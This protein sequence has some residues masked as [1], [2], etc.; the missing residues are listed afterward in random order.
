M[1]L[2]GLKLKDKSKTG[3][4]PVYDMIDHGTLDVL[5]YESLKGFLF[6]L[7]VEQDVSE[8]LN[9]RG[10][11]FVEP[12]TNYILKF[13]V[14]T[15]TND[16]PLNSC[17]GVEK[18]TES[19]ES[20]LEEAKLQQNCWLRSISGGHP[21]ICPSVANFSLFDNSESKKL[22]TFLQTKP[23]STKL[24]IVLPYLIDCCR[25]PSNRLGVIVMPRV[26]NCKP[27]FDFIGNAT[28]QEQTI[29]Y[30]M[31]IAQIVRLFVQLNVLHFD[32]HPYNAL[33]S[34]KGDTL[35]T[36]LIDFGRA[37]DIRSGQDDDYLTTQEKKQI[38]TFMDVELENILNINRRTGVDEEVELERILAYM[39]KLDYDK[40]LALFGNQIK[41]AQMGWYEDY[42]SV[43][44]KY[45]KIP[46]L[47]YK[48]LV[49]M[50][51]ADVDGGVSI[52]PATIQ[53]FIREGSFV[54]FG[55]QNYAN[56]PVKPVRSVNPFASED[57][58]VGNPGACTIS[59]G[60]KRRKKRNTKRNRQKRNT[61]F[62]RGK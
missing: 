56:V 4:A 35:K 54:N 50:I 39:A 53:G 5:T 49:S 36:M 6:T 42:K 17:N 23:S 24:Q 13:S 62:S 32:L 41:R 18:A 22:L 31:V 57:K 59:G 7:D 44:S 21:A 16:E 37:S 14:I 38:R 29:A 26:A 58:C 28:Q 19:A 25:D 46:V 30:S 47:A 12:V 15:D 3:F 60:T 11:R 61:R 20:Y 2:G 43:S 33:V 55:K 27:F 1:Q 52:L 9:L 40:N 10:S 48:M 45:G 51:T 34:G 8:Y